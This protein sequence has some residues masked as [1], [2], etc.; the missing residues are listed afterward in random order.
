MMKIASRSYFAI[1]FLAIQV[2]SWGAFF[3]ANAYAAPGDPLLAALESARNKGVQGDILDYILA[4]SIENSFGADDTA[5]VIRVL[6]RV[7]DTGFPLAPFEDKIREGI[8][9]HI[10][11]QRI[12]KGLAD[13]LADYRFAWNLLGKN[14]R[15]PEGK[16]DPAVQ[17]LV[18]SLDAGLGRKALQRFC[19][20]APRTLPSAMLAVAVRNKAY[21]NQLGFNA[22]LSDEILS[23]GLAN[24]SLTTGWTYFY[25]LAAVSK[26]KG[27]SDE[28]IARIAVHALREKK[29][30]RQVMKSLGFILRNV[31]EGPQRN[32]PDRTVDPN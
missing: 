21:L 29:D 6:I 10:A 15:P 16:S 3:Q 23:T 22:A 14:F 12:G 13:L 28:V 20:S 19:E 5:G 31:K 8:S 30:L 26:R 32:L 4:Y 1:V 2:M 24:R 7:K 25:R 17:T 9:K 18:E 27:I 11:P